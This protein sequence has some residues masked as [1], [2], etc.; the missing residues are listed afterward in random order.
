MHGK[1]D[2]LGSFRRDDEAL[3]FDLDLARMLIEV[4]SELR[5]DEFRDRHAMPVALYE[6]VVR[7]G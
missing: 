7:S 3:S 2:V 4:V 1:A 5:L 6:Q